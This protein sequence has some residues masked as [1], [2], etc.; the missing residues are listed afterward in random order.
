MEMG[1]RGQGAIHLPAINGSLDGSG[2]FVRGFSSANPLKGLGLHQEKDFAEQGSAREI[3]A[4][5][6]DGPVGGG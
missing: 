4:P 5:I 6:Q 1:L 3:R 2:F